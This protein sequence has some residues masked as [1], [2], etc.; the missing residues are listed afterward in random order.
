MHR[1]EKHINVNNVSDVTHRVFDDIA[2]G[3]MVDTIQEL[4]APNKSLVECADDKCRQ[5]L[6]NW[7]Q[8]GLID[9]NVDMPCSALDIAMATVLTVLKKRGLSMGA[10]HQIRDWLNLPMYENMSGLD[11]ALILCR[12]HHMGTLH[13]EDAPF[14]VIDGEN[15]TALC[16]ASDVVPLLQDPEIPT[17]SQIFVNMVRV[18][19]ECDFIHKIQLSHMSELTELPAQIVAKLYDRAT[20]RFTVNI[21]KTRLQ[22]VSNGGENPEYGE[23]TIKYADG[24]VVSDILTVTEVLNV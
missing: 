7:S 9:I 16:R 8:A 11:F 21:E 20:K 4:H 18:L 24:K 6:R 22:T 5:A 1:D 12:K 15:R 19:N 10:L 17:Y 23:R 3:V 2:T 14:L 13:P